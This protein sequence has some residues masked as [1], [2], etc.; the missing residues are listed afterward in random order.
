MG[1]PRRRARS[2]RRFHRAAKRR[3]NGALRRRIDEEAAR[4][5]STLVVKR[6]DP[7]TGEMV[8]VIPR[9]PLVTVKG[10]V[11]APNRMSL[12]RED[13]AEWVPEDEYPF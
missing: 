1:A 9:A 12:C 8:I 5:A 6:I 7:D 13:Q 3:E 10:T 11:A 2:N 4:L